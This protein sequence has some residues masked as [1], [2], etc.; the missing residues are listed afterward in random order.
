MNRQRCVRGHRA[1]RGEPTGWR[2]PAT[3]RERAVAVVRVTAARFSDRQLPKQTGGQKSL[4]KGRGR[5]QDGDAR[6]ELG[7]ARWS[8]AA[9]ERSAASAAG[10]GDRGGGAAGG[11]SARRQAT[12]RSSERSAAGPEPTE[13]VRH[14][15]RRRAVDT[16]RAEAPGPGGCAPQTQGH[17][18]LRRGVHPP[19]SRDGAEEKQTGPKHAPL[20][21]RALP[22]LGA[23]LA[24]PAGPREL[25]APFGRRH[26]PQALAASGRQRFPSLGAIMGC[27]G[28]MAV[29]AGAAAPAPPRRFLVMSF[30]PAGFP[31]GRAG[32]VSS[33]AA[34]LRGLPASAARGRGTR[35]CARPRPTER[36]PA[37]PAAARSPGS[38]SWPPAQLRP[39]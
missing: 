18:L 2:L 6:L 23:P 35:A 1:R 22:L 37:G 20:G 10:D 24:L 25:P 19:N 8:R 14:A 27:A 29:A 11:G 13:V 7:A 3:P 21:G 4:G 16:A 33:G 17:E 28:A 5:G 31:L 30:S 39:R 26:S 15:A 34:A 12:A 32:D 36:S 38:S 9:G